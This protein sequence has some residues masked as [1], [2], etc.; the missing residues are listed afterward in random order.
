MKYLMLYLSKKTNILLLI[1]ISLAFFLRIVN[2][3]TNPP[4]VHAD[5]ADSGYNAYSIL[6]TGKDFYGNFL[7]IQIAGFAKNFRTP[8]ST[9]ITIPFVA[10]LGL[11]IFSI[12]L[13][14]VLLGTLFPLVIYFLAKTLLK[15]EKTAIYAAF[16]SAVSPWAVHIS[17]AYADHILALDL[18]LLGVIFMFSCR[19]QVKYYILGGLFLG[20]SLF[21]YHA[22]KIFLPFILPISVLFNKDFFTKN[23]KLIAILLF[24]FT[25]FFSAV[26]VLALTSKGAQ[27]LNNVSIFDANKAASIVNWERRVTY[28]PLYISLIF[29]NKILY[30]LKE[31]ARSYGSAL[32][33]NNLFLD[34]EG[35]LTAWVRDRGLFYIP[36][37]LFIAVGL[38]TLF[39]YKR[40]LAY[41]L[42]FWLMLSIL[43]GAITIDK[44]YTYRGIFLLPVMIILISVGLDTF[45]ISVLKYKK[46]KNLIVLFTVLVYSASI[47]SFFIH[48]YYDYP[49]YSRKW[50][51]AEEHD[52]INYIIKNRSKYNRVFVNGGRDWA[53]LYAF[54]A[55]TDPEKFQYSIKN[56]VIEKGNKFVRIDNVFISVIQPKKTSLLKDFF[57]KDSLI[58]AG[59]EDFPSEKVIGQIRSQEDWG[60]VYK[61]FE[62]K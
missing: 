8:L 18:A 25:L 37:M 2:I 26:I 11:S 23:K 31:L 24:V 19:R 13:P 10:V 28:E 21:S 12:R 44:M 52:A 53:L 9:Y 34:G 35:N 20:L 56:L 30:Y 3:T 17:R 47:V 32:S 29:H 45:F 49:A 40:K 51:A 43:P 42:V 57:P 7:P 48:Y 55:K 16:I 5:E 27:E 6:K 50:W 33:I 62:V 1:I 15:S 14:A 60:T 59:P 41:F 39:R 38:Y 54:Y 36:D 46:Y 61:I 4:G 22:P 58:I